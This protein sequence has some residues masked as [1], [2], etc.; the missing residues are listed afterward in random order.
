M[1]YNDYPQAATNNAKRAI[2]HREDNGSD[3]GTP[4]G[5]E[6]ARILA[7]R[8]TISHDRT[9]RAYSFLSR[10]KTYDQ[11]KYTDADGN[12]ICGSVM[13][14]AW[15]GD[16][17]LD[18]AKRKYEEMENKNMPAET[19]RRTYKIEVRAQPESRVIEGYAA[20]FETPTDMGNYLEEIAS[21]AFDGADDTDVVALFNHDANYPL[22]RTSNG[23]LELASDA[24]GLFYRFEAPDTTF[25]NDLLKMVRSGLIAQSSF[26]FT[27][28]KDNWMQE[29]GTKPKRRIEQVDM[30]FDVSPVT[31]P[32]YKETSV[33]ARAL[34]DIRTAPQGVC[35]KDFPQLIADIIELSKKA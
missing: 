20:V 26:A 19:E 17:M 10:A 12:E 31:Y 4:V 35:D 23:T 16:A 32:A 24:R 14:D 28:R 30:L 25:G 5:W 29:A 3:C 6:T 11:G 18:W 1:P 15:G 27:I 7:N 21:G 34:Q 13:Y 2:K 8:E 22:A 33:T 9:V